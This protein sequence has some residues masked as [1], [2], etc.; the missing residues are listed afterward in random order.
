MVCSNDWFLLIGIAKSNF[1]LLSTLRTGPLS[2]MN[3]SKICSPVDCSH[4]QKLE[5]SVQKV[6]DAILLLTRPLLAFNESNGE[7]VVN[8]SLLFP[9]EKVAVIPVAAGFADLVDFFMQEA[10]LPSHHAQ[11]YSTKIISKGIESVQVLRR[12]IEKENSFLDNIV[13]DSNHSLQ[14]RNAL[15]G[16]GKS[17]RR[18]D[19]NTE[20]IDD[21]NTTVLNETKLEQPDESQNSVEWN[22]QSDI[23]CSVCSKYIFNVPQG[24]WCKFDLL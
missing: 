17:M 14:I 13:T 8:E 19:K 1:I 4:D 22:L 5:D 2:M 18:L 23:Y 9:L 6:Y 12:H 15:I 11:I 10:E 16:V 21:T 7:L 3:C 20:N 24:T